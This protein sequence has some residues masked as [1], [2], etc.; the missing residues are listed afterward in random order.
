MDAYFFSFPQKLI[1][2][3]SW[4]VEIDPQKWNI[5]SSRASSLSRKQNSCATEI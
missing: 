3:W 1:T 2:Q 4:Y 5:T